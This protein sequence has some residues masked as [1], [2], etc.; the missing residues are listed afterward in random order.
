VGRAWCVV[1][2][3]LLGPGA[4]VGFGRTRGA[5]Q[6]PPPLPSE[7]GNVHPAPI[8]PPRPPADG[9]CGPNNGPQ[10][11][12][13]RA[14]QAT[15][16]VSSDMGVTDAAVGTLVI[17]SPDFASHSDASG[18]PLVPG[19]VGV[20]VQLSSTRLQVKVHPSG[21]RVWW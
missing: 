19:Q 15:H 4:C 2:E 11:A 3:P 12:E 13:C 7:F 9:Q 6:A 17:L 18:G 10:C 1:V 16:G 14:F 8:H 21:D 5:L 20:V